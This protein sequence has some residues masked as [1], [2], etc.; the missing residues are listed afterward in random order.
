LHARGWQSRKAPTHPGPG[1]KATPASPPEQPTAQV[2]MGVTSPRACM[3]PCACLTACTC[4]V[5][6]RLPACPQA[7]GPGPGRPTR[8]L[9]TLPRDELTGA[10]TRTRL[11]WPHHRVR[12]AGSGWPRTR[13][14]CPCRSKRVRTLILSCRSSYALHACVVLHASNHT[15]ARTGHQ[16]AT[17]QHH[18]RNETETKRF[19]RRA[20]ESWRA[21]AGPAP[22]AV[23]G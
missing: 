13:R 19:G 11:A 1:A 7:P 23:L 17:R 12:A 3:C 10:R 21:W 5:F 15:C 22:A 8:Q 14:G 6:T 4:P 16:I 20:P 18:T 9:P 2:N